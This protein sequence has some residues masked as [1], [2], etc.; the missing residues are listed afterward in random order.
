M[1]SQLNVDSNA[2]PNDLN[3]NKSDFSQQNP[4]AYFFRKMIFVET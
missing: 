2:T 3:L 1:L 4:V